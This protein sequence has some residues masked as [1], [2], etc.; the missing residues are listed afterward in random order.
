MS[1]GSGAPHIWILKGAKAGDYAQ[2]RALT[3]ALAWPFEVKQLWFRRF[4]LLLHACPWP[5]VLG[6]NLR[7]SDTM[8]E[9]WP[10]LLLTAGR[11][12]ELPARWV[13]QQSNG[14]TR[15]VHLGRPWSHPRH[16]DLVISSRQYGLAAS[17][18][19]IVNRLPLV[20]P[21][22]SKE[23]DP[24]HRQL[25]GLPK[26]LTGVLVGGN[27]G[28]WVWTQVRCEAFASELNALAA[29]TGGTMVV[30]SSARTPRRLIAC[31]N[32]RLKHSA[33]VVHDYAAS[34]SNPYR[35]TL[36]LADQ[37][38]VTADSLSMLSE[39]LATGSVVY[40]HDPLGGELSW[41]DTTAW[42]WRPL[43]HRLALAVGPHRMRRDPQSLHRELL[44][45]GAVRRLGD[46]GKTEL[47]GSRLHEE[48]LARAVAAVKALF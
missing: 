10:D 28:P 46:A 47:T 2:M 40:L 36:V 35:A 6:V 16:F 39:A 43:V 41:R 33:A 11:R 34:S 29:R 15:I 48:D 20:E 1:N 25:A 42:R 38:V 23:G 21:P 45:T 13:K 17:E 32:E 30:T 44:A 5:N 3:H 8:R 22:V 31:L 26:P 27:S 24:W 37:L 12:N 14:R 4:E 18:N 9:P 19:V 7:T